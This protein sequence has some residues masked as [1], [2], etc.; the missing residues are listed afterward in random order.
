MDGQSLRDIISSLIK[1]EF[2]DEELVM[3][4]NRYHGGKLNDT[5]KLVITDL[6]KDV[7]VKQIDATS[8]EED[9]SRIRIV[10]SNGDVIRGV[11]TPFPLSGVVT[12]VGSRG[13][14]KRDI[15]GPKAI[16][17][18]GTMHSI[19]MEYSNGAVPERGKG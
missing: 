1:E 12:I 14:M 3:R 11:T 17:L 19:W 10:L 6:F 13:K 4:T 15:N 2:L 9:G 18:I 8:S 7:G 5:L 16:Q